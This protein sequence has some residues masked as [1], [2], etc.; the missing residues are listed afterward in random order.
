MAKSP[1]WFHPDQHKEL[2][3]VGRGPGVRAAS[4]TSIQI[5]FVYKGIR[6]RE[7]I[8][9]PP[10]DANKKYVK[11]LK[12]AIEHEIATQTFDYSKHFPES[13]RARRFVSA[14]ISLKAAMANYIQSLA[15]ELEPETIYEY[16]RDARMCAEGLGDDPLNT[17]TRPR[18]RVWV[19]KLGIS[20]KRIN[21][22][23][24][25]LRGTFKQAVEDELIE[26]N[27]LDGFK[28]RRVKKA[29]TEE[30]I[31]PFTRA[32]IDK[33]SATE[34]GYLWEFWVWTGLRS[35]E[36]IGLR[37]SDVEHNATSVAVR[38]AV[39]V[40]REKRPKTERG[41][42]VLHLLPPARN[43]LKRKPRSTME[44][45]SSGNDPLFRNPNTGERWHEDRALARAFRKACGAANVRYRY[46]YQ[47]RHTWASWAL[48]AGENPLWVAKQMGHTD[49][50]MIFKVYGKYMPDLNPKAGQ[51][52][53]TTKAA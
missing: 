21:N 13:P 41:N 51:K 50:T 17:Y 14:S 37:E 52:M 35:G 1:R 39:R 47:L 43:A 20:K 5:D 25:P 7:R 45:G 49:V 6:C 12:A 3:Q 28:V 32:E 2:Q 36:I 24:I 19:N 8:A 46:P 16:E 29:D 15:S 18:I 34:L 27:P 31:D 40:G 53:T 42:R 23:L 9:I 44:H 10:T 4:A 11:R 26:Q 33:L 38:R 22:L 30:V 48:S